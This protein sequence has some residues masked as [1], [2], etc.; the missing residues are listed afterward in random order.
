LR[1]QRGFVHFEPKHA[2]NL[3]R[4]REPKRSHAQPVFLSP[5]GFLRGQESRVVARL[6]WRES[7]VVYGFVARIAGCHA[8]WHTTPRIPAIGLP[9]V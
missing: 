3:A 7:G 1:A 9:L 2:L 6:G 8:S 4:F 5:F